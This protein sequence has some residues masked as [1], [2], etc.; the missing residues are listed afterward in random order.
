MLSKQIIKIEIDFSSTSYICTSCLHDINEKKFHLYKV[1]NKISKNKIIASLQK[2]TQ[3][4]ER[5]ISPCIYFAQIY[6][7]Y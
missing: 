4:K 5:L 1:L 3:L 6:K 2:L 7:T